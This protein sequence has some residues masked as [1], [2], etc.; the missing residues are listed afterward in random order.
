ML[1]IRRRIPTDE[2]TR[3]SEDKTI[4]A[5]MESLGLYLL[6]YGLDFEDEEVTLTFTGEFEDEIRFYNNA[7]IDKVAEELPGVGLTVIKSP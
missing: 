1:T 7:L 6:G 2:F 4:I 3:N 5:V